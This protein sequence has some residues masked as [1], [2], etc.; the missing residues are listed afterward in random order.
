MG[1]NRYTG[2]NW[3]MTTN[4]TFVASCSELHIGVIPKLYMIFASSAQVSKMSSTTF[5]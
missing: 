3:S 5:C 2:V 1:V 4:N